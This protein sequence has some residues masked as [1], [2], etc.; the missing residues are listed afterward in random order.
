MNK[1]INIQEVLK[2]YTMV[3]VLILL[4]VFFSFTTGGKIL[5]PQNINNIISQNAYVFVLATGMLFS[6]LTGGNIDLAVGSTVALVGAIGCKLMMLFNFPPIAAL[7]CMVLFGVLIGAFQGFWIGFVRIPPFICTL[8]GMLAFRG[9]TNVV[10]NGKTEPVPSTFSDMFNGFLP[11]FIGK[12]GTVNMTCMLIGI[13]FC[14]IFVFTTFS[15]RMAKIKKNYDVEPMT[16][17]VVRT[18]ILCL[19]IMF[20]TYKLANYK[21][22]PYVLIWIALIIGIYAY[23][24]SQ[25][26]IGR[27]FYAV[28]GSEKAAKLSG[29]DTNMVYFLAYLNLGLLSG[30]AGAMTTARLNS[31]FPLAGQNYEMDAISACYIGGASAYGGVGTVPGVIVGALLLGVLNMGM[32][33][34]GV[35][36]N[37]QKAIKGGILLAAVI[38]DV[39]SKRKKFFNK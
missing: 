9:L 20:F 39:V 23:I 14:V 2:K 21:G 35:D 6:I 15:S 37:V 28:G 24:A 29:I 34:M 13:I 16:T 25:T 3:L 11:D 22:V 26:K 18:V 19:A 31:A 8:A 38:F 12:G 27:Y 1:K 17:M 32:S 30:I 5:L 33:I 10:L 7:I 4:V 36:Q